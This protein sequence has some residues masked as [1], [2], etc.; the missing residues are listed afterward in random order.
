MATYNIYVSDGLSEDGLALLRTAGNVTSNPKVTP[1][2][3]ALCFPIMT[4]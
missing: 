3:L 2:E 1:E 4:H